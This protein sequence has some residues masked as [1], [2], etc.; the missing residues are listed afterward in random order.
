MTPHA[1]GGGSTNLAPIFFGRLDE[2]I[3]L[4]GLRAHDVFLAIDQKKTKRIS[5]GE[6]VDGLEYIGFQISSEEKFELLQWIE[7][8][9]DPPNLGFKEFTLALKQRAVHQIEHRD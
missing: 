8:C 3:K 7:K 9:L 6:L 2:F 1:A 4:N 5:Y